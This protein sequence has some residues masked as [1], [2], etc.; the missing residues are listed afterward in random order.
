MCSIRAKVNISSLRATSFNHTPFTY[1]TSD[2][3]NGGWESKIVETMAES[4]NFR[5]S[6]V[7]MNHISYY[8]TCATSSIWSELFCALIRLDIQPPPNGELWGENLNGSFNGLVGP[9]FT[10]IL[11]LI[12]GII[13]KRYLGGQ[14]DLNHRWIVVLPCRNASYDSPCLRWE[15]SKEATP[16]LAGRTCTSSL[17]GPG[18]KEL[19][20]KT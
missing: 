14:V 15:C 16:I 2:G 7:H 19:G 1:K 9:A 13:Y 5:Q 3:R 6:H 8:D 20:I 17:T 12:F 11:G 18:L 10:F 4:L